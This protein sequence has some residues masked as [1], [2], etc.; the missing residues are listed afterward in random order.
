MQYKVP[1]MQNLDRSN[2]VN[3]SP[4][5]QST[6][7]EHKTRKTGIQVIARAASIL[8]TLKED[9][10]GLSLAQIAEAIELPRSTVQRIIGALQAERLVIADAR[11]RGYRLGPEIA[12]LAQRTT[13]NVAELCRP[14]LVELAQATGETADLSVLKGLGMICLDQVPS[15]Q[16][17]RAAS[18]VGEV[19]PLTTTANGK[20]ALA[21]LPPAKAG[22]L[23]R[24]EWDKHGTDGDLRGFL[25]MID[26]VRETGFAHDHDRQDSGI[27]TIAFA[28]KSHIGDV[29]AIS[30]PVPTMRFE[31]VRQLVETSLQSTKAKVEKLMQQG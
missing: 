31:E 6:D 10:S 19:F 22:Q 26:T 21:R 11:G 3:M 4:H 5:T 29:H 30:V 23:T 24:E 20:A 14:H 17:L 2:A 1:R 27:S 8:R 15:T 13:Y 16:K 7:N 12:S 9:P 25:T 28:F 18:S